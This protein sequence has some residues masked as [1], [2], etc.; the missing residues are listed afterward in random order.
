MVPAVTVP[1]ALSPLM[2][3]MSAQS[4]TVPMPKPPFTRPVHKYMASNSLSA[5]PDCCRVRPMNTNRGI[6]NRADH[7]M[8]L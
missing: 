5:K 1:A 3:A 6:T 7:F 4:P 2:V 8:K